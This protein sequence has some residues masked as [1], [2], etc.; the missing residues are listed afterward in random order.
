MASVFSLKCLLTFPSPLQPFFLNVP[1]TPS[2][3]NFYED[4]LL[5]GHFPSL[6]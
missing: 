1:S 5:E 2:F 6:R 3:F 4:T